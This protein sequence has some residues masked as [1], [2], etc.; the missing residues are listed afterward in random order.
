[1]NWRVVVVNRLSSSLSSSS[2][3]YGRILRSLF[4]IS[5]LSGSSGG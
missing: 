3:W 4:T 5:V 1:M 2:D